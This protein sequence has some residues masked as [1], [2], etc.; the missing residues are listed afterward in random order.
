MSN[1]GR[2]FLGVLGIGLMIG[3]VFF[4]KSCIKKTYLEMETE[5]ISCIQTTLVER[6]ID[7]KAK[8]DPKEFKAIIE[9]CSNEVID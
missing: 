9:Y 8:A 3:T 6:N 2:I 5:Y 1:V 4:I 7:M